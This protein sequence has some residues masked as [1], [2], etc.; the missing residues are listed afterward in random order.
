MKNSKH[1]SFII[2]SG[3]LVLCVFAFVIAYNLMPR[4]KESNSYYVKVGETMSAKIDSLNI[5]N[6]TLTIKTFGDAKE[7]CVKSTRSTPEAK[8]LCWKSI[9]N[10]TA[11]IQIYSYK[12][13]YIWIKDST[14]NVS[15][16][17]S[18]D[19]NKEE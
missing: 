13:Y 9:K 6:G 4:N 7:Y 16:P 10:N 3:I 17:M 1:T 5:E 18:I 2:A 8:N 12:E 11:T 14:G 19:A 15:S